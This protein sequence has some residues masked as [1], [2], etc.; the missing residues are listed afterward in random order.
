LRIYLP[1]CKRTEIKTF[2]GPVLRY[3]AEAEKANLALVFS[4]AP[5]RIQATAQDLA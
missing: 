3:I 4:H 1:T 5:A 2:Y